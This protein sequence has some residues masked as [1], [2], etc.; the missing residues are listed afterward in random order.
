MLLS[1]S[2]GGADA[3]ARADEAL[4]DDPSWP[5]TAPTFEQCISEPVLEYWADGIS[6][7]DGTVCD[8]D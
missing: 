6:P 8:V 7:S 5:Y 1:D 3:G 2:V 4:F